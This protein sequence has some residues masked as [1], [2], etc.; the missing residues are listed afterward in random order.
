[1]N[2]WYKKQM[3][4]RNWGDIFCNIMEVKREWHKKTSFCDVK[5][6]GKIANA[7]LSPVKLT[8]EHN[9]NDESSGVCCV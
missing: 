5:E 1:M 9:N 2:G 8:F 3:K 7:Y 6:R 4:I